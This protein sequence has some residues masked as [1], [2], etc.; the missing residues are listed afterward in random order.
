VGLYRAAQLRAF[1][2]TFS[3]IVIMEHFDQGLILLKRLMASVKTHSAPSCVHDEE[4]EILTTFSTHT[5]PSHYS[6]FPFISDLMCVTTGQTRIG[7][8]WI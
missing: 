7:I 8:W 2:D 5:L 6:V 1:V 4:V 3:L